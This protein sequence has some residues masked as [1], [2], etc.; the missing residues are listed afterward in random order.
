MHRIAIV[1]KPNARKTEILGKRGE[2][3]LIAVAAPAEDNRA[4]LELLKFL[5]RKWGPCEIVSGL[6][7]KRKTILIANPPYPEAPAQ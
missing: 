7:S 1:V 3:T 4:N 2:A 6:T 5:R